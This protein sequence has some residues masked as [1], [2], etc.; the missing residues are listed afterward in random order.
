MFLHLYPFVRGLY[1]LE[2]VAS[3]PI[4]E[5]GIAPAVPARLHRDR[6]RLAR[7]TSGGSE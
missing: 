3:G 1:Y 2:E 4:V 7:G 5:N 6:I